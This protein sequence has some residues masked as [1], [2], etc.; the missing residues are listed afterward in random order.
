[1]KKLY[2]LFIIL[3]FGG[4]DIYSIERSSKP[5]TNIINLEKIK[6]GQILLRYNSEGQ[7]VEQLVFASEQ[8]YYRMN[9]RLYMKEVNLF[10]KNGNISQSIYYDKNGEFVSSWDYKTNRD[11]S[12]REMLS[13]KKEKISFFYTNE[14]RIIYGESNSII[15]NFEYNEDGTVDRMVE[16]NFSHKYIYDENRVL[17]EKIFYMGEK[18]M[19]IEK[20]FYNH[21]G[22]LKESRFYMLEYD[23][24]EFFSKT[25]YIFK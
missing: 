2:I 11:G 21:E 8:L 9:N 6:D 12:I 3:I 5:I 16:G 22:Y 15:S 17:L 13:D 19:Y 20:Y 25:I 14:K 18:K 24:E 7:R 10:D 1:M 23:E 4:N